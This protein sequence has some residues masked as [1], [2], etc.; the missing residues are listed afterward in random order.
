MITDNVKVGNYCSSGSWTGK[1]KTSTP[2][3]FSHLLNARCCAA[4]PVLE[5][6]VGEDEV[7][8]EHCSPVLCLVFCC[9]VQLSSVIEKRKVFFKQCMWQLSH[10]FLKY[11]YLLFI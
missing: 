7:E 9:A 10:Y 1:N 11:A 4:D 5:F 6:I 8:G 2:E 3:L